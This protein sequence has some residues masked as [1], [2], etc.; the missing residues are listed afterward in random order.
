MMKLNFHISVRMKMSQQFEI[1]GLAPLKE[2]ML[3]PLHPL[4]VMSR[5]AHLRQ[6]ICVM[7]MYKTVT[8]RT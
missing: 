4:Y 5:K 1:Y 6:K 2:D 7:Y 3:L 8:L